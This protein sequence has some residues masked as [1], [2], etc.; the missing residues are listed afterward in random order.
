[1]FVGGDLI[2]KE[3]FCQEKKFKFNYFAGFFLMTH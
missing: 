3:D 1:M 2:V